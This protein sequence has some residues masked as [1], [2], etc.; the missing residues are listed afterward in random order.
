MTLAPKSVRE[1]LAVLAQAREERPLVSLHLK[2]GKTIAGRLLGQKEGALLVQSAERHAT[3]VT[4]VDATR[5]EAITVADATRLAAYLSDGASAPPLAS[6]DGTEPPTRMALKRRCAA[7]STPALALEVDWGGVEDG[8][9]LRSLLAVVE[10]VAGVVG[11]LGRDELGAAALAALT[12]V[13]VGRG[14]DVRAQVA[15][16]VLEVRYRV[17]LGP[18]ARPDRARLQAAIEAA[19]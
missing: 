6:P 3:D 16:G 9:A 18:A 4:Y 8:E 1:V 7:L 5:L 13:R 17:E 15:G 12:L 11:D 10:D 2:S 19:L 14:A